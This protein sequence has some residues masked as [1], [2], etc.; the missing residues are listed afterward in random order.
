MR[1]HGDQDDGHTA[2]ADQFG[3]PRPRLDE[4]A[5]D[6]PPLR[7]QS[8]WMQGE[9]SGL[10]S[11]VAEHE[12]RLNDHRG[13]QFDQASRINKLEIAAVCDPII[14]EQTEINFLREIVAGLLVRVHDLEQ[15]S[16][17]RQPYAAPVIPG[18]PLSAKSWG[19]YA[20]LVSGNA[21]GLSQA[22]LVSG[23]ASD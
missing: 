17:Q 5:V 3:G 12:R 19:P 4:R 10:K 21:R 20:A 8:G 7:G 23:K 22:E 9:I 18:E 16:S 1:G 15:L 14:R 2:I 13:R 11:N 6:Y